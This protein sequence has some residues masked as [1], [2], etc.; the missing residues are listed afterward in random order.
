M[1]S[2]VLMPSPRDDRAQRRRR[3]GWSKFVRAHQS[4]LKTSSDLER[5]RIVLVGHRLGQWGD[6][7]R[8]QTVRSTWY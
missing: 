5:W 3:P 1:R 2:I 4:L 8:C 7:E 6:S